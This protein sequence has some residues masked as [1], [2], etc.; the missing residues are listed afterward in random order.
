MMSRSPVRARSRSAALLSGLCATALLIVLVAGIPIVLVRLSPHL[1]PQHV[2]SV[3]SIKASLLGHDDSADLFIRAVAVF[4]WLAWLSFAVSVIAELVGRARGRA[5]RRLPGLSTQQRWASALI[6]AVVVMFASPAI[7]APASMH[8][9]AAAGRGHERRPGA[10]GAVVGDGVRGLAPVR[11][12]RQ[13]RHH[14][15]RRRLR[16]RRR[17][18][19]VTASPITPPTR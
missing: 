9:A 1:L 14:R 3:A 10:S 17:S 2:P 13:P 12:R 7:A 8:V 5:T 19:S 6:A 18:T 4:G 15:P 16:R 11:N